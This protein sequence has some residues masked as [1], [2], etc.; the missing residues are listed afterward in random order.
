MLGTKRSRKQLA[1]DRDESRARDPRM[2]RISCVPLRASHIGARKRADPK[3]TAPKPWRD[4]RARS[5]RALPT[6]VCGSSVSRVPSR[7]ERVEHPIMFARA[8]R[9]RSELRHEPF[10]PHVDD[11]DITFRARRRVPRSS[12]SQAWL[13]AGVLL[14]IAVGLGY[15]AFQLGPQEKPRAKSSGHESRVTEQKRTTHTAQRGWRRSTAEDRARH[16][17]ASRATPSCSS[18]IRRSPPP[19][20]AWLS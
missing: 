5:K 18:S 11:D 3:S 4:K 17:A 9:A 7:R 2:L 13:I 1:F 12:A 10:T 15:S 14:T 19:R 8:A 16:A 6:S 20:R